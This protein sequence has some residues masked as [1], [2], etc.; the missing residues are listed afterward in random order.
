VSSKAAKAKPAFY[1]CTAFAVIPAA[2]P[3]F[4]NKLQDRT[5]QQQVMSMMMMAMVGGKKKSKI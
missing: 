1:D 4:R 5:Q 2:S 3:K